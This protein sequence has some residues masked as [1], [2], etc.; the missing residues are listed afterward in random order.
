MEGRSDGTMEDG[1]PP[2]SEEKSP[3]VCGIGLRVTN[4][5]GNNLFPRRGIY[6]TNNHSVIDGLLEISKP[7]EM[8]SGSAYGGSVM[9]ADFDPHANPRNSGKYGSAYEGNVMAADQ[10][11]MGNKNTDVS[12]PASYADLVKNQKVQQVN[13]RSLACSVQHE[14]CDIVLPVESVRVVQDKLANTLFG[15]FLGDRIAFPAVDYFVKVNWKKFGLQKSMMNA[16]GFFFFKFEDRKGMLDALAAGPWLIRSQPFFLQEWTPNTKLEKKEVKKVQL[17]VKVHEV[18]IAAYTEDGLSMIATTIGEPNMLDSYTTS[19]CVDNWG[20]SS[21][22]RALVEVTAEKELKERI[23]MAIPNLNGDGFTKETMYVEYEWN[24][25]RCS[26]CCVF[27]HSNE[28]CPKKPKPAVQKGGTTIA[29]QEIRVVTVARKTGINIPKPK[30]KFE[31]RPISNSRK[32]DVKLKSISTGFQSSNPFE[33][34]NSADA[35]EGQ[36]SKQ[37]NGD[38]YDD[39]DD[40]EGQ[41]LL[42]R[43]L[44]MVSLATWNI[45]G[46]NR[47]LKQNEVRQVVKENGVS[48]CAILESHV[49]IN[50]LDKVCSSV[51]RNWEWTSNGGYCDRGTRIIIGWDPDV[52]DIMV[53]A[54]TSQVI[55][56]QMTIKSDK[57]VIFCS[58]VYASNSYITRRDLWSHLIRHKILV[59]NQPWILMGDFNSA[60]NLEDKSMG[61]F[62]ISAS[63]RDFQE[64][65]NQLQVA[66]I[67]SIGFHFTW[68]QKPKKGVGLL[69]KIDRAM[70]NIQFV[71]D[72]PEAVAMFQPYRVSDHCPCIL[73]INKTVR[74]KASSFKFANFLVYKPGYLDVV[75]NNW[76]LAISGV[77]QFRLV[78]KLR[79][80]KSPLRS[81]LFKQG[82]LHKKV[83]ELRGKLDAIQRDVEKDPFN[84]NARREEVAATRAFQEACLDEE[85][86]L[87]QKSKVAWLRAG[88]ANSKFFHLSLKSRNH[89]TRIEGI[90]DVNGMFCEGQAVPEAFVNFYETFL[91]SEGDT[92]S[93]LSPEMFHNRLSRNVADFMVRSITV[94]EVKSAIFAIGNDKAPGPDGYTA[95]FFKSSWDIVGTDVTNAVMDFFNAGRL[96]Q[97]I[98]HTLIV[99]LP[100]MTTPATVKD[101]RPIACCNVI[102][103]CISKI[104]SDRLKVALNDI[105]SINQS[106]FVPGRKISDNILLTQELM[107]NY[108]KDYGP[109]RC[110]FKVDIQKAYDTVDWKFLE[111]VLLGFGFNQLMIKWIMLCV[112]TPSYSICV[113]GSVHGYFKGKRGLRQGDPISPYLFTLVME[114][115]TCQ[116]QHAS[117]IDSSF[118]F[119]NKCQRQR[120]INLCFADDLFLFARGD[121]RSVSCIMN[122]L[123]Q[124]SHMSGLIPNVQ[125]STSFFCN[126]PQHV[127]EAILGIMPFVEGELPVRYLGV[128][129]ISTRLLYKDCSILIERLEKRILNWKNRLL[130]FAGRL[131]LMLSV[132]SS[133]HIF[134]ASVLILPARVIKELET[135]MR[136]FL[137]SQ[138]T[139]FQRGKTKVSWNS[140]CKPKY[141]GGLGLRRIQ[142]VNKALMVSHIWSIITKRDSLWV[143]WI[144]S[145]R[146]RNS[147]FW[148]CRIPSVCCW[149]WRKILQLR[150]IIR[151]FIW[152]KLGDGGMTSAWYDRWCECGPLAI[153]IS[154][155]IIH[156]AGFSIQDSVSNVW[157]DGSWKWPEAWRDLF[158]VLIQLDTLRLTPN[159]RDRL[160]WKDG[161]KSFEY[162][163]ACVWDSIRAR[164][165]E[166]EWGKVVWFSQCIPRHA[167]LMWL[168]M[169]RKLLTQDKILQWDLSRRKNMNMM[170][171]LLCFENN[172][173]LEHLF[174]E[175]K[176]STQIW[177]S[178]RDKV[179]MATVEPKWTDVINWLLARGASKSVFNYSS[180]LTVAA[181]A[182]FIWQE[183]N[184]RLFKNQTRPPDT[185]TSLIL[186]TVRYKLMGVKYKRM[187]KV[188]RFLELWDIHE[189]GML[190]D[191]G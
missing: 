117:S 105:V 60:L 110:A 82:N 10:G 121:V 18:P 94:E 48:L 180:R 145:N 171:C 102:Y 33:V 119:H 187:D 101:F 182:Y 141:E 63:M 134:W 147:N 88:D 11:F 103:K 179:N 169:R 161:D 163:S 150:P 154:P 56:V 122:A 124:F 167:F 127:K 151:N 156:A 177:L 77:H 100:K 57:K 108:H 81:L 158:P 32:A 6:S 178:V 99:L 107:H 51:F 137:W 144:Y 165:T 69:K 58:I 76:D 168:I 52:F 131:Q 106:A 138:D 118:R 136:N 72:Y 83:E 41:A 47:P 8:K 46:L 74:R 115:L 183:R 38:G 130:S 45:R 79:A 50:K 53:L 181:S 132:L 5:E 92:S 29:N 113:N 109:P 120:I 172:D 14:D 87:K 34:L 71:S 160:L 22:A 67:K 35:D 65:V 54:Q 184:A 30:P 157:A 139:S 191:A 143:Q 189:D 64:C 15:Y 185:I 43:W 174:F 68:T 36:S 9:E 78:K 91:G 142:D 24:P 27:G 3:P 155:R 20:R 146:L 170:C 23:T 66:D 2:G 166:V 116:L 73:R 98:N 62:N 129:L 90:T 44:L 49:D 188:R 125:K 186:Q 123:S 175:C 152:S 111:D 70:S 37:H 164:E 17:W 162:S 140:I 96:L 1:I 39:S 93:V 16:N 89:R 31:Y 61:S 19:M 42:L 148:E 55:H 7:V 40:E 176:F 26:S 112:S 114:V 104:L 59:G 153:F 135:K 126:V 13:F 25:L 173:S 95:A 97:E 128:P 12:K 190:E 4:I 85:R 86:F 75:K 149:S 80:L 159:R 84:E 28:S 133:M 21:F